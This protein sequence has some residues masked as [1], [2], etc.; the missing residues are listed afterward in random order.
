M[1]FNA[2]RND[3][4]L[5]TAGTWVPMLGAEFR[6]A[7][8][9]NPEYDKALEESG[10]RKQEEPAAKQR[11]LYTAIAIGVLK[12]W[13]EV[14]DD[15]GE[16]IPYSVDNAVEVMLDNPDLVS[17]ILS[18]AN[19]LANFRREDHASQGKRRATGSA[20]KTTGSSPASE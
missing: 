13:R 19:D 16:A 9:G 8:A 18:E 12:D 14:V 10:Y 11:A 7:R 6:I 4:A 1:A 17:R 20:S 3:P 2:K 15:K 5:F